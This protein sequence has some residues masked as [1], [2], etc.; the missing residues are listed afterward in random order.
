MGKY[1]SDEDLMRELD[2]NNDDQVWEMSAAK[3]K[4]LMKNAV[5]AEPVVHG[6]WLYGAEHSGDHELDCSVCGEYVKEYFDNCP[7]CRAIMD[8][9]KRNSR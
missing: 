5:E 1:I 6:M 7:H 3:L 9:D 4:R 8:A 2:W